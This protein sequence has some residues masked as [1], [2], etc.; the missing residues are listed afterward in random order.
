[1][2]EPQ[3]KDTAEFYSISYIIVYIYYIEGGKLR[4]SKIINQMRQREKQLVQYKNEVSTNTIS[5][6]KLD[7]ILKYLLR[8]ANYPM[9][10]AADENFAGYIC[11]IFENGEAMSM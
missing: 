8:I 7:E 9:E 5:P 3:F 6:V 1:M 10:P 2:S 4:F 11:K